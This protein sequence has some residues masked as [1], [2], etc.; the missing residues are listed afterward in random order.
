MVVL[1]AFAHEYGLVWTE[2]GREREIGGTEGEELV[3]DV[4]MMK[5]TISIAADIT[6]MMMITV[7]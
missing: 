7:E 1:L 6:T 3:S 4:K 5:G 2:R